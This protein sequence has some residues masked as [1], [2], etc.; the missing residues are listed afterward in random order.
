MS[1]AG[2]SIC[3]SGPPLTQEETL[4]AG[5]SHSCA[6]TSGGAVRCWG[7]NYAGQLGNGSTT[8]SAAPV[9]VSG[10]ASGGAQVSA[11]RTSTCARTT[12]GAVR[13]FGDN[14]TGIAGAS[15]GAQSSV[16]MT[17]IGSGAKQVDV[18]S[19]AACAITGS[20]GVQC[21]GNNYNGTLGNG[22]TYDSYTPVNVAGLSSGVK[23]IAVGGAHACAI[24]SSSTVVC[25]GDNQ[26][27]QLG[28]GTTTDR[29]RP[30]TVG[31]L[32]NVTAITASIGST[33]AISG[34]SVKCW[35]END[36][37]QLGNGGT[38]SSSTPVQVSGLTSGYK[39]VDAGLLGGCALS[40]GGA[41]KCW[42]GDV[43]TSA[44]HSTT[45]VTTFGSGI[46][47]ISVGDDHSCSIRTSGAVTC[48]GDNSMKQLGNQTSVSY[49]S[50]PVNGP[51]FS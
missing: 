34:G 17:I 35:G 32:S 37:S 30:V 29:T 40:T 20:G 2:P 13:C 38:T 18:G 25:W 3:T 39:A 24:T 16:P 5:E 14:S 48:W 9:T 45:P 6:V 43:G 42:G 36:Q 4:S 46:A 28:D 21:W 19:V 26:Y 22:S 31:G 41:E 50:T 1:Y 8:D 47:A 15:A 11:G 23:Q 33:C 49:S 7:W 10:F 44:G 27:G 12:G 51:S